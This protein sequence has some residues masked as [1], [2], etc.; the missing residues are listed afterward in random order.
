MIWL[1]LDD[2][3]VSSLLQY[4]GLSDLQKKELC[5]NP[6]SRAW[7][8]GLQ[9]VKVKAWGSPWREELGHWWVCLEHLL[10]LLFTLVLLPDQPWYEQAASRVCS[11]Q[12]R[13]N[14]YIFP[15]PGWRTKPGLSQLSW[16]DAKAPAAFYGGPVDRR[17]R[18]VP[19]T[20]AWRSHKKERG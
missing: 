12:S 1:S 6:A 15:V 7:T 4:L 16:R 2:K 9:P 13:S 8:H 19:W 5:I 3:E 17:A 10:P 20:W 11:R 18:L 14:H